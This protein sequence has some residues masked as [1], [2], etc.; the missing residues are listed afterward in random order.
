MGRCCVALM[1]CGIAQIAVSAAIAMMM[2]T[3]PARDLDR[4]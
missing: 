2:S 4:R 1:E 3:A